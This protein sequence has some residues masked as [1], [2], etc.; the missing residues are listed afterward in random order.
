VQK[1]SE[2]ALDT[3]KNEGSE[4]SFPIKVHA[5]SGKPP[6]ICKIFVV[7]K[8]KSQTTEN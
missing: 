6:A 7:Q 1:H 3:L 4:S 8:E 5:I 2:T